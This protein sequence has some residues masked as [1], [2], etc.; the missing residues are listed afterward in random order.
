MA[1]Q[2][3]TIAVEKGSE[4]LSNLANFLESDISQLILDIEHLSTTQMDQNFEEFRD[5]IIP[6]KEK[7]ENIK[8]SLEELR[9]FLDDEVMEYIKEYILTGKLNDNAK[10]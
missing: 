9:K 5:A 7:L 6:K 10:G 1:T 8:T 4:A 2:V 3:T